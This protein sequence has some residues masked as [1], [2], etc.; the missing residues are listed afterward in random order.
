MWARIYMFMLKYK[1]ETII[2]CLVW[3]GVA[4]LKTFLIYIL[5]AKSGFKNLKVYRRK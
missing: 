2:Y 1:Q 4:E 5:G 3:F